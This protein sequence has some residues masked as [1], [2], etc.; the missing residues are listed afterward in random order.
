MSLIHLKNTAYSDPATDTERDVCAA[1][2]A[3]SAGQIPDTLLAALQALESLYT[4]RAS[5]TRVVYAER[6]VA[7]EWRVYRYPPGAVH[8]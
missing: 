6:L 4:D 5:L 3:Y 8:K 2:D 7:N 1:L